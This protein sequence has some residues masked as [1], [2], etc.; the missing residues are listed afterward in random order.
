MPSCPNRN[1]SATS[2]QFCDFLIWNSPDPQFSIASHPQ[3]LAQRAAYDYAIRD[4][5]DFVGRSEPRIAFN[6]DLVVT[7]YR[8]NL[9]QEEPLRC[10][11]HQPSGSRRF[12][13]WR[14]KRQMPG[15]L[16]PDLAAG[17]RRVKGA[18][19]HGVRLGNWLTSECV[20]DSSPSLIAARLRGKV[21]YRHGRRT[22]RMRTTASGTCNRDARASSTTRG[23]LS[24]RG[25]HVRTIP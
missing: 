19:K 21:D 9:E 18:R 8:I 15:L 2:K 4:F 1:V 24:A 5:I 10:I 25:G 22:P 23:T 14:T 13:D 6:K 7:R 12:G 3:K 11:D 16:S 17:I 20:G